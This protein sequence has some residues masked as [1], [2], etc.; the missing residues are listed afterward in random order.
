MREIR[1][2]IPTTGTMKYFIILSTKMSVDGSVVF[3]LEH[4]DPIFCQVVCITS[5]YLYF[6]RT[7]CVIYIHLYNTKL[8]LH[9]RTPV[10]FTKNIPVS[11]NKK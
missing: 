1:A 10:N 9:C 11:D 2:R 7:P 5:V 4:R 3:S 6:I 8:T